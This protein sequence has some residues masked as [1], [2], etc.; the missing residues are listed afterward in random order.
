M[1]SEVS[2]LTEVYK[3]LYPAAEISHVPTAHE[4]FNEVDERFFSRNARGKHS[5]AICAYWSLVHH[6]R[7][8][9]VLYF[10]GMPFKS[11]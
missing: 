7:F 9:T 1:L 6:L 2:W 8:G 4:R 11:S 3:V 5:A 10:S